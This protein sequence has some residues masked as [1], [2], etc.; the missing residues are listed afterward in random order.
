MVH[1]LKRCFVIAVPLLLVAGCASTRRSETAAS[2]RYPNL[3]GTV[4]ASRPDEGGE[5]YLHDAR[6]VSLRLADGRTFVLDPSTTSP[7]TSTTRRLLLC[8]TR[9]KNRSD[10]SYAPPCH[11]EAFVD[12]GRARWI[13][14]LGEDIVGTAVGGTPQW[15]L[16]SDGTVVPLRSPRP[17]ALR[18]CHPPIT[19]I[20]SFKRHHH[21]IRAEIGDDSTV[22]RIYCL[23]SLVKP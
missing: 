18:V 21:L 14:V 19:S 9:D 15:L 8:R 16:L 10:G 22:T 17:P 23:S 2:S 3:Y 13:T 1:A 7:A 4:I 5:V 12:D 11:I 20:A 6:T